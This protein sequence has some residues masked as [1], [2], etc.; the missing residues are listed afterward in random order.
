[1]LVK[2]SL[3]T[4]GPA[5]DH[6]GSHGDRSARIDMLERATRAASAQRTL[7]GGVLAARLGLRQI[8]LECLFLVTLGR[9]V[10]PGMLARETG[11]TSG[12]ITGVVDR[13][14]RAGY[15]T[16]ARDPDDRRRVFLRPLP[17]RVAEIRAINRR[18]FAPWIR[19][20]AGYSDADLDILLDFANRNH[21]AAV[22]AT[23]T[24]REEAE[25]LAARDRQR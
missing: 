15:I 16:R 13:I 25:G 24:L 12:A 1:M 14:E 19:T 11:L 6:G 8:D 5:P 3:A 9:D 10:T 7:Y 4:Q 23:V 21:L 2:R 20:L 22:E 17:D 18:A